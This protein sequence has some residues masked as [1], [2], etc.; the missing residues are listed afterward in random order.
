MVLSENHEILPDSSDFRP[1]D[2]EALEKNW[3]AALMAL[4]LSMAP[5]QA[6]EPTA[7]PQQ[8]QQTESVKSQD[9]ALKPDTLHPEM[10]AIAF[11]ESSYGGN[12]NH[13]PNSLGDWHTAKGPLGF[14]PST[15]YEEFSK[16]KHLQALYP[17]VQTKEQFQE[18]FKKPDFYNLVAASHWSRLKRSTGSPKGAALA[19]RYGLTGHNNMPEE[20]RNSDNY[21][22]K[23]QKLSESKPWVKGG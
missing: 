5:A 12:M 18:H 14:K 11:L 7:K 16:S 4:G 17:D 2:V 23:Y 3:K 22:Q 21:A 19:W 15:A 8:P 1:E 10:H 20:A 9:Y 6:S 13:A